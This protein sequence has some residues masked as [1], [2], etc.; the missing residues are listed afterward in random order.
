VGVNDV[1]LN[2]LRVF[3]SVVEN[4]GVSGAARRLALTRSAVS[5]SVSSLEGSLGLQLFDRVGRRLLLTREG[6]LL[7]EHFQPQQAAL[8]RT[9][10]EICD[11][12]TRAV[13]PV[14]IGLF[15]GFARLK[16]AD[17]V[18][19]FTLRHPDVSVRVVYAPQADLDRRLLGGQLDFVFSFEPRSGSSPRIGSTRL[20][21]QELVL[22]GTRALL[23]DNLEPAALSRRPVIDYYRSD[24]LIERWIGHHLEE[25]FEPNVRVWAATTDLVLELLLRG[26]GIGVLPRHVA[27]PWV[28]RRRL[29]LFE[30][31]PG[32]LTDPIWLNEPA[33]RYRGFALR[34]FRAA[35]IEDLGDGAA[36]RPSPPE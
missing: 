6:R 31:G 32:P 13:G 24:P 8:R 1:D 18:A 19:R 25:G 20:F 7:H 33:D 4:G 17:F 26:A 35:V 14:R 23:R 3:S 11:S 2:K 15:P 22:A 34:A 36:D 28:R 12:E 5:Q 30:P 9:L 16:L 10:E 29:R 21:E 27:E